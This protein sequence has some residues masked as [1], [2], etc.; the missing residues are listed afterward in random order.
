M[1]Y[2]CDV[3]RACSLNRSTVAKPYEANGLLAEERQGDR[4]G[5]AGSAPDDIVPIGSHALGV[6]HHRYL[7][8]TR[9]CIIDIDIEVFLAYHASERCL[10]GD[11]IA[12]HQRSQCKERK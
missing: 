3:Y 2:R 10:I 11:G 1:V 8:A 9:C 4:Q 12:G 6:V 7:I 5:I